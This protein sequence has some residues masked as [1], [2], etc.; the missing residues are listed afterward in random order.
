MDN[1]K[2]KRA[3]LII[4][5]GVG[6]GP[7]GDNNGWSLADTPNI[8]LLCKDYPSTTIE[9]SGENVGLPKGQ[10][11]NSEVGH[12]IIGSGT[13]FKQ[14]LVIINEAIADS[15]F[16]NNEAILNAITSVKN[17]KNNLHLLGLASPGGVHSHIDH[18]VAILKM[19][20]QHGVSP[21]LHLFTDG[22]DADPKS[23]IEILNNL[24]KSLKKY[25]GE[26]YTISGRYYGM[27]RDQRWPRTE[28]T[29]DAIVNNKGNFGENYIDVINK[30]Y[31]NGITDEF[32]IPTS[33]SCAK[34][35]QKDDSLLFFNFRND[36]TRQI[37]RALN[38]ER[39]ENF[40]RTNN[41]TAYSITTMTEYD[42]YLSCP[43]AYRTKSPEV[44]LGSV[45]SNLKLKQFHCA[46]TEKYPHVTYFING[47]RED[48]YPGE[49]RVLIPSPDVATYDLQ[50]EMSVREVAE[51]VIRAI[52][53][54]DYKLIVVN[55]A[56]GDMVGHTA[57]KDAIVLAMN[58]LDTALGE[59][60]CEA[61]GANVS[62][63]ITADH[64]NVDE[65]N[66]PVTGAPN[67][68]HSLNP[69]PCIVIDNTRK[70]KIINDKNAGISNIAP[71]LLTLMGI[72]KPNEMTSKT[73]IEED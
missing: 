46:E 55:F 57:I 1:S 31:E 35:L 21:K 49:K 58:E 9:A 20:K 50:P 41:N 25:G 6:V 59:V 16:F 67:T 62:T 8:D 18:L 70:W 47:G 52:K 28:L 4:L 65:I 14:D 61:L 7:D 51:E 26:I 48:P 60:V 11:G 64:G 68:Q 43:V 27:D 13:I 37:A 38:V 5:D 45:I 30:S 22:R 69:V 3:L 72:D 63:V 42:P 10:M 23:S 2:I 56:N 17:N 32:I 54:I 71:T 73:L 29:W 15:S 24:D 53:N 39:F 12:M 66:N 36:R 33:L 44:T 34:P 19:C 40:R